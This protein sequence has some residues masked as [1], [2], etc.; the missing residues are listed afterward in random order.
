VIRYAGLHPWSAVVRHPADRSLVPPVVPYHD[1]RTLA[2]AAGRPAAKEPADGTALREAAT[3][4]VPQ[5]AHRE[6]RDTDV[7]VSDL[8]VGLG[9]AAAHTLNHPGN[10][11][12]VTLARRIQAAVGCS[13]DAPDPGYTLIGGIRSPLIAAVLAALDL[14]GPERPPWTVGGRIVTEEAV[15]DA[16]LDWYR[17]HPAWIAAGLDRHADALRVLGL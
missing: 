5:L 11:V 16:Q 7:G 10:P 3:L 1:L 8:L 9:A 15:R 12:L 13:A 4:S 14:D 2:L 6:R 17:E